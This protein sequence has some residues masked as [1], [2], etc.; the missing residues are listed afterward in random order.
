[1]Y[2]QDFVI[3]SLELIIFKKSQCSPI[4][5]FFILTCIV[6]KHIA[7]IDEKK[8]SKMQSV[9]NVYVMQEEM[10]CYFK[11]NNRVYSQNETS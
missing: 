11:N 3:E 9:Q 6:Y 10:F 8:V 1:M 4:I 2:C 7:W 5:I